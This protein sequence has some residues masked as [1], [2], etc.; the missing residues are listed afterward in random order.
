M[1]YHHVGRVENL[2]RGPDQQLKRRQRVYQQ[3]GVQ[4]ALV[5]VQ[6]KEMKT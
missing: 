5:L 2:S 4:K 3:L 1:V 6:F